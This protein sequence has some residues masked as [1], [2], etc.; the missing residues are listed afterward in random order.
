MFRDTSASYTAI[1]FFRDYLI[2]SRRF[3]VLV[4]IYDIKS[5]LTRKA[6]D[7]FCQKFHIPKDVHP[8][9]FPKSTEFNAD[10]YAILVARSAPFWKFPEPFLCLI[11]MSSNY[12]LDED[13]YPTFLHD[14]ETGGCLPMYIA[15]LVANPTK[16]KV[17]ERERAE[18][19]A[20]LLESTVGHAVPLLPVVTARAKRKLEASVERLFD[21]GGSVNQVDSAAGGGQEAEVGIA[22][23]V[24]IVTEENVAAE[25]PRR[26]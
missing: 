19:E 15:Q 23:G 18:G 25:R 11:G 5:V 10:D 3:V 21:E 26:L 8:D 22:T 6:F 1:C 2:L 20:R 24:R 13:T 7:I 4:S 17:K 12:T 14:D 9:P 16:V